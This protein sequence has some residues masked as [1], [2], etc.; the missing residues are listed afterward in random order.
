MLTKRT[1]VFVLG[2]AL[3]VVSFWALILD[4][5]YIVWE[6]QTVSQLLWSD[7]ELFLVVNTAD[8][9]WQ[10][11]RLGVALET[12]RN[13]AG[14]NTSIEVRKRHMRIFHLVDGVMTERE[15]PADGDR[16]SLH[17]WKGGLFGYVDERLAV[18][19]GDQFRPATP[20]EGREILAAKLEYGSYDNLEGWSNRSIVLRWGQRHEC[21]EPVVSTRRLA[22]CVDSDM[23]SRRIA[24]ELRD[25]EKRL[26]S[27]SIDENPKWV[28]S[29]EYA[30]RFER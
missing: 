19:T 3:A 22:F 25:G 27:W 28:T 10:G 8:T 2:S 17:S 30:A 21:T 16:S 23:S 18:W 26:L 7:R 24:A 5:Q 11:G 12:L 13:L 1:L 20:D 14:G 9:G 4:R 6:H 29:R 15:V